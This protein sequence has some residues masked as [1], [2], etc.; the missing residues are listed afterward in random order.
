VV[1]DAAGRAAF[2]L[3]FVARACA[4]LPSRDAA[5]RPACAVGGHRALASDYGSLSMSSGYIASA[6]GDSVAG[7][8]DFD[9]WFTLAWTDTSLRYRRTV[10]GP[11]WVTLSMGAMI[12][13]V[14]LVFG[15]IF[16][17]N[18]SAYMPFFATGII[19]W[20]LISSTI[21]EGCAVFTQSAGLIKSTITPLI[22]HVYRM[23]ARQLIV[24][25][26][27]LSLVALVWLIF[28][29]PINLSILLVIP[30]IIIVVA[31]LT[32]AV[33]TLGV[34]CTR[35]RDIQQI[36]GAALQL[37]F[38]L[39]PILWMPG[40]LRGKRTVIFMDFNPLYYL[41]DVV[42]GPILGHPPSLFELSMATGT[43]LVALLIGYTMFGKFSH[44]IAFWL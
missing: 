30:G 38:L 44:R 22:T 42:R 8:R 37:F 1:F 24:F 26:H 31:T 6:F 23:M 21:L 36:I 35:F 7:L 15:T 17:T 13:S 5:L 39:T 28:R 34:L 41:V 25:T 33:L 4:L 3:G 19:T 18:L 12:G 43:A 2:P 29:W 20:T 27:N 16:G 32:G 14:G 9:R 11:W 10:L 40:S